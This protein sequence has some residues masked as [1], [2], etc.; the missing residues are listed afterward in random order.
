MCM[1]VPKCVS[2]FSIA[3]ELSEHIASSHYSVIKLTPPTHSIY[4]AKIF[5]ELFLGIRR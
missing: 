1:C 4:G 3:T 5:A 2:Y